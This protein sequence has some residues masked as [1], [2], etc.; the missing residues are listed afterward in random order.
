MKCTHLAPAIPERGGLA[1]SMHKQAD[2]CWLQP[3]LSAKPT[4]D[5]DHDRDWYEE[6]DPQSLVDSIA[7]H[8]RP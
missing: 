4:A 6:H 2:R 8:N 1:R 7:E 3:S 5:P